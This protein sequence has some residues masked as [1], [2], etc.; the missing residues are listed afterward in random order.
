MGQYDPPVVFLRGRIVAP[1]IVGSDDGERKVCYGASRAIFPVQHFAQREPSN[2][3]STVTF[4]FVPT[5]A[6]VSERTP[7][8]TVTHNKKT[9]RINLNV[10]IAFDRCSGYLVKSSESG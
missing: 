5:H 6:A 2:R 10:H 7:D 3:R 8:D 1:A 9:A 4:S